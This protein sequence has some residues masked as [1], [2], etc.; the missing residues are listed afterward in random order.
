MSKI[1][2]ILKTTLATML[3]CLSFFTFTVQSSQAGVCS[4]TKLCGNWRGNYSYQHTKKP[5]VYFTLMQASSSKKSPNTIL[6]T[7]W[8]SNGVA[9]TGQG[10]VLPDSSSF[11]MTW[12]N[13]SPW[14]FGEYVG[15][16]TYDVN[17]KKIPIS[18][19]WHYEGNDCAGYQKGE[20]NAT[21]L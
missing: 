7:Y 11:K 19:S 20:A 17:E 6:G 14:C 9:G 13:T 12:M 8:S 18:L 1:S 3:V 21:R 16:Y 15:S 4:T 2:V 5:S 10:E